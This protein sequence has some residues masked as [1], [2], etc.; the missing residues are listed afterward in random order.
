MARRAV[1][2]VA[3]TAGPVAVA[4]AAVVVVEVVVA[5]EAAVATEA[6]VADSVE[7]AIAEVRSLFLKFSFY[8]SCLFNLWCTLIHR[9]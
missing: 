7:E 4:M 8:F 6:V 3:V 9:F 1:Q 5:T 2:I